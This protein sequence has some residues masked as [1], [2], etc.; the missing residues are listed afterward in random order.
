MTTQITGPS[1]ITAARRSLGTTVREGHVSAICQVPRCDSLQRVLLE[2]PLGDT[3]RVCHDHWKEALDRSDGEILGGSLIDCP[4]C[5]RPGCSNEAKANVPDF[6]GGDFPICA[7]HLGDLSW[8]S[9]NGRVRPVG[10]RDV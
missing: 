1:I 5:T 2:D 7:A 9:E 10:D 3:L 8:A 6:H 4:T